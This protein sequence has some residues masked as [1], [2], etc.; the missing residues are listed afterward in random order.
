MIGNIWRVGALVWIP[1]SIKRER[2]IRIGIGIFEQV[3]FRLYR[4]E[5]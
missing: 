4:R 2:Y 5:V 3:W 1:A